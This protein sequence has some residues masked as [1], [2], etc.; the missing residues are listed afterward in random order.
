MKLKTTLLIILSLTF[1]LGYA[2][3]NIIELPLTP[4]IGYGPF[5]MALK[6]VSANNEDKENPW[7]DTYLKISKLPQGL[8]E[9]KQ[10]SIDAYMYQSVYQDYLQ[11]NIT[12]EW[13]EQLQKS[14]GWIPDTLQ[15]SKTPLKTKVAFAYGKDKDGNLK[16]VID[17]NNNLDLSDDA[18]LT[19]LEMTAENNGKK[20]LLAQTHG[21]KVSLETFANGQIVPVTV[22]LF[23]MYNDQYRTFLCNFSQYATT[24]YEGRRIAVVSNTF[25]ELSYQRLELAFVDCELKAGEKIGDNNIYRK[26][27]YIEIRNQ[28]YQI[29]GVNTNKNTL[30]LRKIEQPKEQLQSTQVGYKAHSFQGNN[31][32]SQDLITSESLKGKYVLL[33]FWAIWCGPC[34]QEM[35]H[36][37]ELYDKV[38]RSKIEFIGIVGDSQPAQLTQMMDKY[39]ITWPQILSDDAN[40]IKE[41]FGIKSYPTTF[42]LDEQGVI[43]AKNMWGEELEK[44]LLNLAKD[45][46]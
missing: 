46:F 40:G 3:E 24:E 21:V 28:I 11:G 42:L 7:L 13:Y 35:P 4:E 23:M 31:F 27:E 5:R 9:I 37:K 44:M 22:P 14:W 34:L 17:A 43:I 30:V 33:D 6:G 12:K 10:G 32:K 2:Q 16:L 25:T 8:A 36:L 18:L 29:A 1:R 19:P 20:E 38:D 15:L 39:A 41:K 45:T 26:N